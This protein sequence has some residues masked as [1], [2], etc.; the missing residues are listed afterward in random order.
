MGR[1]YCIFSRNW[2]EV[3]R[4]D[5]KDC[6]AWLEDVQDDAQQLKVMRWGKR[7]NDREELESF[8]NGA[9]VPV[10]EDSRI[11]EWVADSLMFVFRF[12]S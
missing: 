8:I 5:T 10:S 3:C 4:L 11:M 2:V 12:A 7:G 9:R 1:Y 6:T